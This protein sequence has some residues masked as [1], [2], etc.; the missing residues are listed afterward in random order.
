M[1]KSIIIDA[2]YKE[3]TRIAVIENGILQD[4]D[5]ETLA[6]KKVK[7]NIYAATITRIEPSLQAAFINYGEEKS[8]FLPFSDIH[9]QYYK[10]LNS[11]LYQF[12]HVEL[13]S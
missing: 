11:T 4:F 10:L 7:G 8:G 12:R 13:N 6:V 5:R 2:A 1:K 9:P 3:E